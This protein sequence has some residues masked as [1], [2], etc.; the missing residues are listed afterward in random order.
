VKLN[1]SIIL[2]AM[3]FFLQ[4]NVVAQDNNK[5]KLYIEGSGI[6]YN[7]IRREVKFVDFVRDRQQSDVHLLVTRRRAGGSGNEYTFFFNGRGAFER[8]KD[9]LFY[10]TRGIDSDEKERIGFVRTLKRGLFSFVNR[11][12]LA[13]Y[14]DIVYEDTEDEGADI[15][16]DDPWDFWVFSIELDGNLSGESQRETYAVNTSLNAERITK[17]WKIQF[18]G[19]LGYNQDNYDYE[20][21]KYSSISRSK[22]ASANFI[23]SLGDHFGVGLF[24][25]YY[26][27][28]YRNIK[29]LY[30]VTPAIEYNFYPYGESSTREITLSYRLSNEWNNYFEETIYSR[31]SEF[32]VEQEILF[33]LEFKKEWGEVDFRMNYNNKIDDFSRNRFQIRGKISLKLFEGV[34][35]Y[36]S[37]G[38]SQIHNQYSIPKSELSLDELLLQRRELATQYEFYGNFGVSYTFGSIYN[39]I[40]NPRF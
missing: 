4:C 24:N 40:V 27:S 12:R 32:I 7:Y 1:Y 14:F 11:T 34:G 29:N 39:N 28:T 38:Y 8:E 19:S 33:N 16:I 6:D 37:G 18:H 5:L 9:T 15:V 2:V 3:L 10:Y 13:P 23:K 30:S 36:V 31:W 17:E 20:D 25:Y 22:Y 21:E 26:S 35:I